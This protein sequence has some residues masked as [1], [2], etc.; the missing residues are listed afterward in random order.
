MGLRAR[1]VGYSLSDKA[2]IGIYLEDLRDGIDK[3]VLT[4]LP[5]KS[6]HPVS[7]NTQVRITVVFGYQG[8]PDL[9]GSSNNQQY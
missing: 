3:L 6:G 8:W 4:V 5:R 7:P 2:E 9:K 1:V